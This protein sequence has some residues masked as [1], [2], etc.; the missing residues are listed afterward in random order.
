M[1]VEKETDK[2]NMCDECGSEYY[3]Q[4]SQMNSLCPECSHNLYGYNNCNHQFENGRCVK[5]F[6]K[7]KPIGKHKGVGKQ[8]I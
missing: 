2:V 3:Q 5:C 7:G 4:T 1:D 6:W 8:I